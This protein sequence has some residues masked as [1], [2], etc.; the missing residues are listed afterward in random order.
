M[1]G[2]SFSTLVLISFIS[3]A[4]VLPAASGTAPSALE[5]A[6]GN[7]SEIE[8]ALTTAP[9]EQKSAMKWLVD[10]MPEE[11][12]RKL[13]ASF[14]LGNCDEA[15]RAWKAAP[16][17][18]CVPEDVFLDAIL[19]YASIDERR[20]DWRH[21]F[22]ERF[23]PFVMDA[24]TVAQ[25]TTILNR[26]VFKTTGVHYS[27]KRPKAD[28]SPY[29]T[30]E[31]KLASCTGLSVLLIDACRA[32]GIPA[33]FAG[34]PLWS[35]DSGNHSW[36]EVWDG[37]WHFTGAAEPPGDGALDSAWFAGRAATATTDDPRHAIY[38]VTWRESPISFPMVWKPWDKSVRAIDVTDRYTTAAKKPE[39]GMARVRF[40]VVDKAGRVATKVTVQDAQQL[41]GKPLFEGLSK[42]ERFDAN[43]HLTAILPIGTKVRIVVGGKESDQTIERD[44]QLFDF[45]LDDSKEAAAVAPPSPAVKSTAIASTAASALAAYLEKNGTAQLGDQDFAK[46]QIRKSEVD[47]ILDILWKHHV[48]TIRK[49]RAKEVESRLIEITGHKMPFWYRTFGEKPKNGRSLY[50]SMH[51]GGGAP[52]EVNDQQWENQKKLYAP[53]E[54]IYLAPRAPTD[55]WNLWHEA[56]IDA[57]FDR[58]IEDLIV[59]EDVDPDRVYIMGYSAGGDGVYQLAPR[60]ADRLA[61][62]AMMAGHPNETRPDGLRN[63]GFALHMGANDSAYD[64]NKIA[65]QWIEKL[66]ELSKSD[67]G[68]YVHVGELH[69]GKGHWMD[70]EDKV[71]VP[72]MAK[73][74]RD[75]RPLKVVW[76]QDDVTH[77]RFYWLG[78]DDPKGGERVVAKRGGQTFEIL[79]ATGVSTLRIYLDDIMVDLDDDVIVTWGGKEVF[80]GKATRNIAEMSRTLD[81]R[82]DPHGVYSA[83]ITVHAPD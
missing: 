15:Y 22:H 79:E 2:I 72:W 75:P 17:Q 83:E 51:G 48:A 33:R 71:A 39:P 54:G 77:R 21:D 3:P 27:T 32:C 63:I 80:R 58:L 70:R 26:E 56:H 19:P 69:A 43:D 36:V 5:R 55:T 13:P 49:E 37:A 18:E 11:D 42:D 45:S 60:I 81:E 28:Q 64:R 73:F 23:M 8:K 68:G 9:D 76:L 7:R 40:R 34:T 61:A 16:W 67:P 78:M 38:A 57:C 25:A 47:G 74:T 46:A 12:L 41:S 1:I 66:D 44:E 10:H 62:A 59:F 30:I 35:D 6:G 4:P 52:K 65:A 14:L 82:G 53:D 50:I 29:E 20:D 31:A 24:K